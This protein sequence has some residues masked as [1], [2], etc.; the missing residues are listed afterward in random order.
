MCRNKI[1]L[2]RETTEYISS[3]VIYH[4]NNCKMTKALLR[5]FRLLQ[6]PRV[7][8]CCETSTFVLCT[9]EEKARE[10]CRLWVRTFRKGPATASR[11]IWASHF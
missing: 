11:G 2:V 9:S 4:R 3:H 7:S 1:D 10:Y 8:A 5:V 6:N